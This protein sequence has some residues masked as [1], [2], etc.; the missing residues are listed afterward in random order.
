MDGTRT[1]AFLSDAQARDNVT[2]AELALDRDGKFLGFRVKTIAAIGAYLQN[3]MPAFIV[4]AGTLAGVYR[5]PAMYVDITAV[6][7]NT[8]PVRPYRG[9]GRPEAGYVIERMVDLAADQM[10]IDPAELRRRNYHP[11]E[12]D[13]VQDRAYVHLRLRRIRKEHGSGAG[14]RRH[15]RLRERREESRKRSKLRGFGFS[16]T[17]ERAAAAGIEGA[18][19]RFDRSGTV[20]IFS[21]CINHGQG[22]ETVFK[23][24]V[25]DRLGLH[26]DEVALHSG[27]HR[28][29]VLRRR[30]RRFALGDDVG[31][32]LQ[33]GD[34][35][36]RNKAKAIA[37]QDA[38][39]RRRDINFADGVFSSR[40]PTGRMTIKEVAK[41]S[42]DPK[43]FPRHGSRPRSPRRSIRARRR[44]IR[45]A[46]T[47]ASW[48]STRT[49]AWSRF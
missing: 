34:R 36:D 28:R 45:T 3:D 44:T 31:R 37:A 27:R 13:A 21:G 18:E 6:F 5:T 30:H 19:I 8:K 42:I 29:G 43:N 35:Q 4:N 12:R 16:N 15:E 17:I 48:K 40:K 2:E 22:H 7:T 10:G 49:P 23:Q 25:C 32:G 47:S 46:A 33:L 1:E 24:M 26:P 39:G 41:A 9:N 20:T 11:A 14:A 38:Q